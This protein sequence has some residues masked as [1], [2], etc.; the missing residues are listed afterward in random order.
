VAVRKKGSFSALLYRE[1]LLLRKALT[2]YL[3]MTLIYCLMPVL[4]TL[5]I[6]YGNLA[7][8]PEHIFNDIRGGNDLMLK[9]LAVITP[10]TL[11]SAASES[12]VFDTQIKWDRFRRSTPVTPLRMALAKYALV[13]ILLVLS[14]VVAVGIIGLCTSLLGTSMT[15]TDI[16]MIMKGTSSNEKRL[17]YEL[18]YALLNIIRK[19]EWELITADEIDYIRNKY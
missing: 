12:S 2:T 10:C 6:R 1:L 4:V 16:A 17:I 9:L 7:M 15:K 11:S 5:S 13:S 18:I 8:L 19:N 14:V 3:I